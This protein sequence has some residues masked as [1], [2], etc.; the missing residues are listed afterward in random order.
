MTAHFAASILAVGADPAAKTD[1]WSTELGGVL[2]DL[3]I[4]IGI[5]VVIAAV[6]KAVSQFTSGKVGG[7]VKIMVGGFIVAAILFSPTLINDFISAAGSL[8]ETVLRTFSQ[9]LSNNRG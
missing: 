7:G 1:F 5:I 8:V 3:M 2:H 6:L 4:A 9:I